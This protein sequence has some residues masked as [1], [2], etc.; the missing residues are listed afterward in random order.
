M[1]CVVAE[2]LGSGVCDLLLVGVCWVGYLF[3]LP[4]VLGG[5]GLR[6]LVGCMGMLV[7]ADLALWHACACVFLL[8]MVWLV[9]LLLVSCL[10]SS[11]RVLWLCC[12]DFVGG[13]WCWFWLDLMLVWDK[14]A[15]WVV[16]FLAVCLL[17]C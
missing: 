4:L 1:G 7:V 12:F 5:C 14:F 17:W 11:E 9:V 15:L 16:G 6:G 8:V 3:C 13:G 10:V 2:V